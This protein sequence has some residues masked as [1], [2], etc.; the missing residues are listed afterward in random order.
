MTNANV[1]RCCGASLGRKVDATSVCWPRIEGLLSEPKIGRTAMPS[2]KP[3]CNPV[4]T[5][6]DELL[7]S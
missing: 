3:N 7:L 2:R 5:R 6:F 4:H 1:P